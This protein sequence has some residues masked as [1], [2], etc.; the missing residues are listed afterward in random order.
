MNRALFTRKA[1]N[2]DELKCRT[3]QE[4]DK[5]YFVIE[6]VIEL[7]EDSFRTFANN[8]LSDFDFIKENLDK[9]YVDSDQIWHCLLVKAE[10]SKDG[11]LVEAEGYEYA[12]YSRYLKTV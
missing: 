5:K 6:K 7:P 12:R 10:G 11:I 1:V 9:M 2:L 4:R 8:L 3:E